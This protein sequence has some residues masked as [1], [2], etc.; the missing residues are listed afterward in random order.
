MTLADEKYLAFTTFKKDGT[1]KSVPVWVVDTGNG[2][3]GFT[4]ASSSWKV[5][6]LANNDKI[7]VQP[8]NAKG[9][10]NQG[11][12]LRT[13]TAISSAAEFERVSKLVKAKYGIQFTMITVMG[14]AAKLMGKG[15]GT[16]TAVLITLD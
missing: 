3:I 4:T 15:S 8:C 16:D 9:V 5:R 1:E 13:G 11:S 6:R 10:I 7:K 12:S 2:T 14:K